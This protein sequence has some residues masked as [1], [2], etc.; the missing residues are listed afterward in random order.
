MKYE[1]N[2]MGQSGF[3]WW[4]GVVEDRANDPLKLGRCRVRVLGAHTEDKTMIPTEDLF[5]AYFYQPLTQNPAMN[6][7]GHSPTGP[8]EATWVWGVW[9]D[10]GMQEP[11][12]MGSIHGIP[13]HPPNPQTG[14]EDPGPPFHV[15]S[16][17]PRKIRSRYYPNDGS[18][19]QL[20]DESSATNYPRT[21]H[22]WGCIVGE[23]DVNRLARAESVDDTIIGVRRRQ[24]DVNVPIALQH[25]TGRQWCEPEPSYNAKYPYNHVFESESGHVIEIDDTP[26]A[27]RLHFYH[28]SGTFIEIQGGTDGDLVMKCVGK[29]FEVTMEQSYSHYQHAM[30]VTVDGETNIYCR[31]DANLQVDGNLNVH[32][33]GDVTE[34]VHGNYY[35][36]IDGNRI[37]KIGGRDELH[38]DGDHIV[39]VGGREDID[40]DGDRATTIGQGDAL[41]VDGNRLVR[42]GGNEDLN[43]NGSRSSKIGSGESLN[44]SGSVNETIGGSMETDIRGSMNLKVLGTVNETSGGPFLIR[45]SSSFSGVAPSA[46]VGFGFVIPPTVPSPSSPSAPSSPEAPDTPNVPPFPPRPSRAPESRNESGPTPAQEEKPDVS[47]TSA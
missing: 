32:V 29:R 34:K 10:E 5:W 36:D 28:R 43:V 9:R 4:V 25:T 1:P 31:N 30:N 3:A 23:N 20:T 18:G 8:V 42:V 44:V 39:K 17:A 15:F 47:P 7:L 45:S 11:V 22:P 26:G 38:V 24:R 21:T 33:Q 27:E 37:V 14:F 19:A 6:G 41:D 35:T 40:I 13:S 16:D 2:S 46:S 12:I